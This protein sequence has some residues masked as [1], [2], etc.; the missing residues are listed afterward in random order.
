MP[1][2]LKH[3]LGADGFCMQKFFATETAFRAVLL[4][5]NLLA[6]F[7]R[8][9]GLPGYREPA[10][11]RT[12]V[13]TCGAILGRAGSTSSSS[14]IG[15]LGWRENTKRV[16]RQH[17]ALANPNFA[18]VQSSH[19]NLIACRLLQHVNPNSNFGIQAQAELPTAAHR[20]PTFRDVHSSFT[21]HAYTA[22]GSTRTRR[23]KTRENRLHAQAQL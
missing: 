17:L 12:Q 20:N 16:T 2:E 21:A 5:F 7:Q 13:L 9:A 4:I 1:A 23:A 3:D 18:E 22:D 15:E 11:L 10:T 14:L 8:A 19:R 6:E